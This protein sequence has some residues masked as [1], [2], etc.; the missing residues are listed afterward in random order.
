[1]TPSPTP[2]IVLA[3]VAAIL[4]QVTARDQPG[5]HPDTPLDGIDSLRVLEAVALAE[6]HFA[7][8]VDTAGIDTLATV[9][10]IIRLIT[11]ALPPQ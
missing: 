11:D 8:T 2:A 6:E 1:M 5:L 10:D 9:G 7:V 4:E 3:A